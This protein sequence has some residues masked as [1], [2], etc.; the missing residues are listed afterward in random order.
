MRMHS[1]RTGPLKYGFV[2]ADHRSEAVDG[3]GGI[4]GVLQSIANR[5]R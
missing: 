3:Q 2:G 4:D 1:T 5:L